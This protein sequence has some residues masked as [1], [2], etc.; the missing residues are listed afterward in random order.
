MRGYP[1]EV[2]AERPDEKHAAKAAY[3][4]LYDGQCEIC[5]ACVSWL[6]ALDRKNMTVCLPISA[7]ALPTVD[8]RLRMDECLR[9]LHVVTPEGEIHVG[10]DAVTC[11]ARLFPSTWLIG[12]VGTAVPLSR[13]R[14][15]GLRV[16][17]HE[18]IFPQQMSRGRLQ[19]SKTRDGT[20]ASK[21]RCVLVLLHAGILH[22]V[23]AR[24]VGGHQGW[25]A[26]DEHF[27]PDLPQAA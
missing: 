1:V 11:L 27:R 4:V 26:K 24:P 3:R 19:G 20:A 16:R 18:Q 21:I 6:R 10:W 5:Q 7:D 13:C 23:A 17:C 15:A 2:I 22:P 9:Q 14:A 12:A 25:G 8:S